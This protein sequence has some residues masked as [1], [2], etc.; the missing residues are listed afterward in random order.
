MNIRLSTQRTIVIGPVLD[1]TGA[2]KTDEVVASVLASKNGGNPTALD[3]SATLTHKQTGF[4]LLL[5]T[6]TDCNALGCLEITLNSGTNTMSVARLN[7]LTALAWDTL[8]SATGTVVA[9]GVV[10]AR[11]TEAD[12]TLTSA[13][14]STNNDDYNNMWLVFTTGNNKFIPRLI[15]DFV[16]ATKQVLFTGTGLKG[17]FPQTVVAGDAFQILAGGM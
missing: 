8:H 13:D 9:T 15:Q 3:G 2:A 5:L 16:G 11:T 12:F 17:A 14:L 4:Y 6:A 7:V 10:A 1:S